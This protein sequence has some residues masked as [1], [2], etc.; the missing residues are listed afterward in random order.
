MGSAYFPKDI[1]AVLQGSGKTY[2]LDM[3]LS[4]MSVGED[5][6]TRT[7]L[8]SRYKKI[9]LTTLLKMWLER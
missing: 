3:K 4:R 5:W 9:E 8:S 7:S 2:S 1:L 6:E